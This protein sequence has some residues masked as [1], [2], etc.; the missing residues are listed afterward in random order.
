[1]QH[2]PQAYHDAYGQEDGAVFNTKWI[3]TGSSPKGKDTVRAALQTSMGR[4][5]SPRLDLVQ[6]YWWDYDKKNY[7]EMLQNAQVRS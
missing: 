7:V 4:M 2:P 3:P 6:Y 5:R 1:M